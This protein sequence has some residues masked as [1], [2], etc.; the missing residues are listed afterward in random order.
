MRESILWS[1]IA[2]RLYGT[3]ITKELFQ[4]LQSWVHESLG[5]LLET[6]RS[7][8]DDALGWAS[9][10][11]VFVFATRALCGASVVLHWSE[12]T[13]LSLYNGSD[14]LKMLGQFVD[15]GRQNGLNGILLD[16]AEKVLERS[17]VWRF[18]AVAQRVTRLEKT[19]KA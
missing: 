4:S 12:T 6:I 11:E 16:R 14:I 18:R 7:E 15:T 19:I 10:S 13:G 3:A 9:K 8:H 17:I 2:S 5:L 1:A